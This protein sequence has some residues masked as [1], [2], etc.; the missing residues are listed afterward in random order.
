[1]LR[2][3]ARVPR[4]R[5]RAARAKKKSTSPPRIFF[6]PEASG[7]CA[8][9]ADHRYRFIACMSIP[10]GSCV[11]R[12]AAAAAARR[13]LRGVRWLRMG[14]T[15]PRRRMRCTRVRDETNY[16]YDE[17]HGEATASVGARPL[18][19]HCQGLKA[20]PGG[21]VPGARVWIQGQWRALRAAPGTALNAGAWSPAH[22]CDT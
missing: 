3:C 19:R 4:A 21:A 20:R 17:L 14:G 15:L 2:T 12:F 16:V 11:V 6:R 18:E 10:R 1:M 13:P 7:S 5:A 8:M 22:E 9:G